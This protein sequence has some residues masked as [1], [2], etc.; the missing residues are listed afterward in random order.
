MDEK[1]S[2]MDA[3]KFNRLIRALDSGD[4]SAYE[5]IHQ[6]YGRMILWIGRKI[7]RDWHHAQDVLDVVMQML[8]N[9]SEKIKNIQKPDS[10][11]YRVSKRAAISY[12]RKYIKKTK[13][14]ISIDVIPQGKTVIDI[15]QQGHLG[16]FLL[17]DCL[18][19]DEQ[20]IVIKDRKSVV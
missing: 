12:C 11:I 18:K 19:Q 10:F 14:D 9:K 4:E 13:H 5:E 16:F 3:E 15:N 1:K 7:T 8:W 2:V 6:A 17:I 20:D